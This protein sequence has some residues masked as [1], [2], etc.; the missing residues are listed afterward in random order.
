MDIKTRRLSLG[1]TQQKV[2]DRAGLRLQQYQKI[3]AGVTHPDR[4][5]LR[6]AAALAKALKIPIE[7][8]L[9]E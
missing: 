3:E 2:A 4:M 7:K 1:L 9:E 8:L 6:N 5:T